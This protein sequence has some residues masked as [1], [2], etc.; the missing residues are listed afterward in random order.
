MLLALL[1][2]HP[3]TKE[4]IA[5]ER[6]ERKQ[7]AVAHK[8]KLAKKK[9]NFWD[10]TSRYQDYGLGKTLRRSIWPPEYQ[11]FWTISRVSMKK[12]VRIPISF[13]VE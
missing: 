1:Y 12:T 10:I 8:K 7:K 5:A 11:T 6:K 3:Q 2:F 9:R 13:A 4:E